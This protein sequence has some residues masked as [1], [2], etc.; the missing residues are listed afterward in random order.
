M[1]FCTIEFAKVNTN[2]ISL[3]IP[4]KQLIVRLSSFRAY[5]VLDTGLDLNA[6]PSDGHWLK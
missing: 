5:D 6:A 1:I 3:R 2:L 4:L